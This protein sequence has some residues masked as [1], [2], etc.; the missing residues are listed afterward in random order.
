[1]NI[2]LNLR[3]K[4]MKSKLDWVKLWRIWWQILYIDASSLVE[5]LELLLPVNFYIYILTQFNSPTWFL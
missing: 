4:V 5:G 2:A 1:M 3:L